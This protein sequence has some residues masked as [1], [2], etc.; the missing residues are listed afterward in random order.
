MRVEFYSK[1]LL[2][3]CNCSINN[4]CGHSENSNNFLIFAEFKSFHEP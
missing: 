1:L 3:L 4:Y 2:N